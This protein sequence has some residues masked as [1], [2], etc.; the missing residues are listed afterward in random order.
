MTT[1]GT[2]RGPVLVTGANGYIAGHV[3]DQLLRAGYSVRGTMRSIQEPSSSSP[4][5]R[6]REAFGYE[7]SANLEIVDVPDITARSAFHEASKGTT[8]I[9]HI[10]APVNIFKTEPSAFM[11]A[12]VKGLSQALEAA[13]ANRDTVKSFVFMSST[14]A[15]ISEKGEVDYTFNEAGWNTDAEAI[16][17]R[18]GINAAPKHVVYE[19]SK[20]AAERELWKF[21]EEVRPE[22]AM[23]SINP[24]ICAGPPIVRPNSSSEINI[25][26]KMIYDVWNGEDLESAGIPGVY[27][28]YVDVRDVA[29]AVVYAV[30]HPEKTDGE[31]FILA[32]WY[33]PPQ[34]VADIL[35][36]QYSH[37]AH[38]IKAGMEGQGYEKGYE[39]PDRISF[40][41]TKIVHV[42]GREYTPWE[43]TVVDTIEAL[44]HFAV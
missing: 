1:G 7:L 36:R 31:R 6:L 38:R 15:V 20:V 21:R 29:H 39:F 9:I 44:K 42:T 25:S 34:A 12:S 30:D 27:Q 32:R 40:D 28:G 13:H 14:A 33:S 16:V 35:R 10:A 41:G 11:H 5:A 8:A 3:I 43:K 26:N 23:T 2:P 22:F 17:A 18:M 19:A 24:I 37:R 4:A